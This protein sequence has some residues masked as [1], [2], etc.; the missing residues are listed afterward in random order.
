MDKK[1]AITALGALAQDT[2]LDVFR[3]LVTQGPVGL[4]AGPL[5]TGSGCCPPR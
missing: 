4:P 3:L 1:A 5:P 2:R